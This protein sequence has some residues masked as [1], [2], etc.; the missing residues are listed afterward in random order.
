MRHVACLLAFGLILA[1]TERVAAADM[2]YGLSTFAWPGMSVAKLRT[3]IPPGLRLLCGTDRDLA[4]VAESDRPGLIVP[5][6]LAKAGV[7]RCGVFATDGASKSWRVQ[8]TKL[9]DDPADFWVLVLVD[10]NGVARVVQIELAQPNTS[11]ATTLD[12]FTQSYGPPPQRS[13]TAARWKTGRSEALMTADERG[14]LKIGLIDNEL[15]ALLDGRIAA[16]RHKQ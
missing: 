8:Q 5:E 2:V 10:A 9:G 16:G 3:K 4:A 11:F 6:E 13:P 15:Q 1:A 12:F 14:V 7:D